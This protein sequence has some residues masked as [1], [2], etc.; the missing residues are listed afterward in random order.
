M[1][2]KYP[3]LEGNILNIK[4][5]A[6]ELDLHVCIDS[7]KHIYLK[8]HIFGGQC[9]VPATMI[10]ELLFESAFIYCETKMKLNVNEINPYK[11]V[12]LS[13][14][15]GITMQIGEKTDIYIK[16][17]EKQNQESLYTFEILIYSNRIN[18]LGKI[19]AIKENVISKVLLSKEKY[20]D[21]KIILPKFSADIY[22]ISCEELYRKQF[23]GLKYHFQTCQSKFQIDKKLKYC[24]GEFDLMDKER[25]SIKGI[26]SN[27]IT[28]PLGNDACLQIAVFF[29]RII[30][31][32]SKLPIGGDEIEIICKNPIK[33][34]VNV[35]LECLQA[36]DDTHFNITSYYEDKIYTRMK[37]FVVRKSPYNSL[38]SRQ[39]L[40]NF[41]ISYKYMEG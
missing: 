20:C 4:E 19:I 27:F 40:D 1:S 37:N 21:S 23:P 34:K 14:M 32:V 11:L 2:I 6:N 17:V 16:V 41:M 15:R 31:L 22:N 18:R 5:D 8:E 12:D 30:N 35:L 24:I 39:E 33:G 3:F 28:S 10:M 9:F 38:I 29:S 26:E 13:I 36:G 25:T 7:E